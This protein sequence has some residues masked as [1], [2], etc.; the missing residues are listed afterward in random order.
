MIARR[1]IRGAVSL[2]LVVATVADCSGQYDRAECSETITQ[3]SNFTWNA[4]A[5]NT[6]YGTHFENLEQAYTVVIQVGSQTLLAPTHLFG[7]EINVIPYSNDDGTI[8][9]DGHRFKRGDSEIAKVFQEGE[10]GIAIKHHCSEYPILD[11]NSASPQRILKHVNLLD[12]HV[13]I[14]IGVQRDGMPG[15][16]TINSP[17]AYE[18][19]YFGD[20]KYA[21][22][23]LKPVYPDYLC[24][25]QVKAFVGN[26]RTMIVGFNAVTQFPGNYTRDPLGTWNPELVHEHVKNMV[27][28]INGDRDA[29][30]FFKHPANRVYCA[31]LAFLGFSSGLLV[32]LN[33]T[34]MLPLVGEADWKMFQSHIASHNAGQESPFTTFNSNKRVK[35][36]TTL[37]AAPEDLRPAGSYGPETEIQKLAF[38]PMTISDISEHFMRTHL[39]RQL[40]GETLAPA[41]GAAL[42][43]MKPGL[44]EQMQLSH[45]PTYDPRRMTAEALYDRMVQ[46]ISTSYDS[47]DEFRANIEPLLEHA[48]MIGGPSDDSG[49][50]L[51]VPPSLYHIIAQGRH[52]GGLLRLQ[53]V[54]HGIH[55]SMVQKIDRCV[56]PEPN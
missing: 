56:E 2:V 15:A 26:I 43:Q 55:Q 7:P 31:E 27:L 4:N 13:E 9:A 30:A 49:N 46:V 22:I 17:Q 53:Y 42:A 10:L 8:A 16:I 11:L 36:V 35:H 3:K 41:Q 40:L 6:V 20:E 25:D 19:G 33:D 39:Q 38:R 34:T 44:L 29:R 1:L 18:G 14:V 21:M 32:P 54:G 12:T 5:Y 24:A 47:Y 50:G 28:A 51:F 37:T 23:F 52:P 45:V 48:R